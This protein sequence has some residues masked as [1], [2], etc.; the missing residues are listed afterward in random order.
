MA[1]AKKK[2]TSKGSKGGKKKS[3]AKKGKKGGKQRSAAERAKDA[4]YTVKRKAQDDFW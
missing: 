4:F 2:Q 3:S 1:G